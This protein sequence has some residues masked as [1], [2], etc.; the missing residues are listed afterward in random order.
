MA[1]NMGTTRNNA[2][3]VDS[4]LKKHPALRALPESAAEIMHLSGDPNCKSPQLVRLIEKDTALA[5]AVMKAV[6]S[7]FYSLTTKM[8]RLDRAVAYLGTRTVKEIVFCTCLC[9][10]CKAADFGTYTARDLWDHGICVAIAARELAVRSD[11]LDPE[12]AFLAG[13][14]HDI[15]LM[16][17]A[18]SEVGQGTALF[19]QAEMGTGPFG[20]LEQWIFGFKHGELGAA[21]AR[22][23]A[24]PEP[25]LMVIEFHHRPDEA[26]EEYQALCHHIYVADTLACQT[27]I[28][29]PL[30]AKDQTVSGDNLQAAALTAEMVDEVNARLPLLMRLHQV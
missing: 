29:C 26:P 7:S 8:T 16:L 23:W 13:M 10:M 25:H 15:G 18:Q 1:G 30:S 11:K 24:F 14:L 6:N 22:K 19:T 21:L 5:G 27:R 20:E 9:T 28:G 4:F 12:E 2:L 3:G 17:A